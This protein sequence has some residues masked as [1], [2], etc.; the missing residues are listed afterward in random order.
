MA[1]LNPHINTLQG[2]PT[3]RR[4][5]PI[6]QHLIR[7][8]KLWHEFLPHIPKDARY[9][10][11]TKIDTSLIETIEAT[12]VASFLTRDKKLPYVQR[13]ATKLDLAKFFLQVL[14]EIKALDNKKYAAISEQLNEVGRMLGGW[15]RQITSQK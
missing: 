1:E 11:G 9:T 6:L 4:N 3:P 5:L 13:A 2:S 15:L 7:A 10:L 8:Y 12:F 14:W